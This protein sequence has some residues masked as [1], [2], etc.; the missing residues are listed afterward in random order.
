METEDHPGGRMQGKRAFLVFDTPREPYTSDATV[1]ACFDARFDVALRKVLRRMGLRNPDVIRVA[2]GPRTLTALGS[3]L[4]RVVV[5]EQVRLSRR[6]HGARRVVLVG[7][8]DCGAYGGL[9]ATFADDADR[10]RTF[11][12]RELR[13]AAGALH[14]GLGAVEV[15][16]CF[17]GFDRAWV[18][19]NDVRLVPGEGSR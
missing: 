9:A 12:R 5:L 6:L 8:S 1:L 3:P 16:T 18:D 14:D 19:L 10:E 2:G 4:E 7:H 17:L 11:L 13:L 15:T